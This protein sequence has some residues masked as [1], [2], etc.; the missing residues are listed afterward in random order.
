[1]IGVSIHWKFRVISDVDLFVHADRVTEALLELERSIPALRDSAVSADRGQGTLEID[2]SA[3][4][5]SED[6]AMVAGQAAVTAAIRAAEGEPEW[7]LPTGLE[8]KRMA[9]A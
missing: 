2:V 7:L 8:T 4:A 9:P 1:M 5:E 3:S 6:E